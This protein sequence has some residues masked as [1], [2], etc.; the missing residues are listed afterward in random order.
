LANRAF[1]SD[2][3]GEGEIAGHFYRCADGKLLL[4]PAEVAVVGPPAGVDGILVASGHWMQPKEEAKGGMGR[5]T[6]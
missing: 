4:Q 3:S 5:V 1:L 2:S 6:G